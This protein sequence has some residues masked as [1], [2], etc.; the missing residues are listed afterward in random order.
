MSSCAHHVLMW[1]RIYFQFSIM[2]IIHWFLKY[3]HTVT[4]SSSREVRKC[5]SLTPAE[6]ERQDAP[7]QQMWPVRIC[8]EPGREFEV[9]TGGDKEEEQEGQDHQE[10][11]QEDCRSKVWDWD[12]PAATGPP[13]SLQFWVAAVIFTNFYFHVNDNLSV[14][15]QLH[16]Y[17]NF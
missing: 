6:E 16:M 5:T 3:G 14:F 2:F 13:K 12:S 17:L 9:G 10:Y 8:R 4:D 7:S 15:G 11:E 1:W